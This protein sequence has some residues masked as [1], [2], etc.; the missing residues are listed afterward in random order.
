MI[1]NSVTLKC[2]FTHHQNKVHNVFEKLHKN[3]QICISRG[4]RPDENILTNSIIKSQLKPSATLA[5]PFGIF[6][7]EL[8]ESK[9]VLNV[10]GR[11][12]LWKSIKKVESRLPSFHVQID[13]KDFFQYLKYFIWSFWIIAIRSIAICKFEYVC[14]E[15]TRKRVCIL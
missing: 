6:S 4:Q 11:R 5:F 3:I 14:I 15:S 8:W 2:I 7:Y 10:G 9:N 13:V 12:M 1:K